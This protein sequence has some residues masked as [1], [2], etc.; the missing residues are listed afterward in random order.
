MLY[1]AFVWGGICF[2]RNPL[3]DAYVLHYYPVCQKVLI[4]K[5][6]RY[7]KPFQKLNRIGTKMLKAWWS[8][9]CLSDINS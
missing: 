7:R 6:K 5:C 9:S 2:T 8:N 4:L 1:F 3:C